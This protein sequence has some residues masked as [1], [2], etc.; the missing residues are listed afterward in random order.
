MRN[1]TINNN[2]SGYFSIKS[3]NRRG[4][5]YYFLS[6][7]NG[8]S[9]ALEDDNIG[10]DVVVFNADDIGKTDMTSGKPTS[11]ICCQTLPRNRTENEILDTSM[12]DKCKQ[13]K[14]KWSNEKSVEIE[15]SRR[16]EERKKKLNKKRCSSTG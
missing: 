8:Q 3:E 1:R 4:H 10:D 12:R 7:E 16:D 11:F 5:Y 6:E 2:P 13:T 15:K 14:V 9:D